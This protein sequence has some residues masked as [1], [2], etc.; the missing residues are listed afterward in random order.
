[1]DLSHS[2]LPCTLL[3][4]LHQDLSVSFSPGTRPSPLAGPSCSI[5]PGGRS[6]MCQAELRACFTIVL[7]IDTV[8]ILSSCNLMMHLEALARTAFQPPS[9]SLPQPRVLVAIWPHV[10][11]SCSN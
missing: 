4:V 8:Q 1:M 7:A 2:W 3:L 11:H 9:P 5:A 6:T 10:S